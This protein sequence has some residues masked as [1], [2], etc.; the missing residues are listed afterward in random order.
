VGAVGAEG[1]EWCRGV[2]W[3]GCEGAEAR[4]NQVE[5]AHVAVRGARVEHEAIGRGCCGDGAEACAAHLRHVHGPTHRP[6]R[7]SAHRGAVSA[8]LC[9][10]SLRF[11]VH[12]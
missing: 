1:A 4:A 9:A 11:P 6:L 3:E 7:E 2:Q 10:R 5:D 8:T 12:R